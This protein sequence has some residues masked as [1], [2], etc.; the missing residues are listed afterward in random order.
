MADWST[1]P[2]ELLHLITQHLPTSTDLLRFRS[3]CAT[4]RAALPPPPSAAARFPILPNSGISDTSWGFYLSKRTIYS[5][6]S[7]HADHSSWIIKLERDHPARMHL[8]S[9]LTPFQFKP[10]P[11][12]FPKSFNL[13]NIRVK[14]LGE[15]YILQYINFRPMASSIGEAGNLYREKVAVLNN[16][17]GEFVLLTIHLSGKLVVYKSGDENWKV[18]DDLPSPYDDVI[19]REG[20]FYAVDNTGRVVLVNYVDLNVSPVVSSIFGGDKKFLVDSDG[21]LL[22]VDKY[23]SA[24]PEDDL[25]YNEGFEFYEEFDCYMSERTVKFKVFRLDESMGKWVEINDLGD[26]MLFLGDNCMFSASASETFCDD[27]CKGNCILFTETCNREDDGVW[28]SHG[29]GVFDLERGSIGPID[30]HSGCS[31]M[32]W[33]PPD[34]VYSSASIEVRSC[35]VG[36]AFT[37]PTWPFMHFHETLFYHVN[38]FIDQY[39]SLWQ[40]SF[41][42]K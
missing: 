20:K 10:L 34:W 23:L 15:E 25:G 27:K 28:N 26:K 32:F 21:E 19:L 9:P 30:N 8:L 7:P 1:L 37:F 24:G 11:S 3:V 41:L 6:Q 2:T 29:V 22:L 14:E 36:L 38:P 16:C 17:G 35:L 33:P 40:L 42:V 39:C 31:K 13:F 5:L 18:I 4:W 12:N